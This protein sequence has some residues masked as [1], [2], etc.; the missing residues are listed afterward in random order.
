MDP[1]ALRDD[2]GQ[3]LRDALA[4]AG[5]PDPVFDAAQFAIRT[6]QGVAHLEALWQAQQQVD[7]GR[8]RHLEAEWVQ[9]VLSVPV[10]DPDPEVARSHLRV[11]ATPRALHTRLGLE[12]R[13]LDRPYAPLGRSLTDDVV[14]DVVYAVP[15]HRPV[16]VHPSTLASWGLTPEAAYDEGLARRLADGVA[17]GRFQ[18]GA[19]AAGP[20]SGLAALLLAW[21]DPSTR[22]QVAERAGLPL[23]APAFVPLRDDVLYA[24]D[25]DDASACE[26]VAASVSRAIEQA[27]L[28]GHWLAVDGLRATP[29]GLE[30]FV[31]PVTSEARTRV[32]LGHHR[33]AYGMAGERLWLAEGYGGH[34]GDLQ[35]GPSGLRAVPTGY[36]AWLGEAD[37]VVDGAGNEQPFQRVREGGTPVQ[38]LWPPVWL[39]ETPLR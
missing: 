38:G 24:F 27:P 3:R 35:L 5:V 16:A 36:P 32:R 6:P 23:P 4:G 29:Q 17:F 1:T 18:A 19:W 2:L 15:G 13:V 7:V 21:Q 10:P 8:R 37:V 11:R 20:A 39:L 30:R 34:Q 12:G 33:L 9:S 25:P 28:H 14:L 22:D 26:A 31:L